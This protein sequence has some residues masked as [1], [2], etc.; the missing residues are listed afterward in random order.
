MYQQRL[1]QVLEIGQQ[2]DHDALAAGGLSSAGQELM[3]IW[4]DLDRG[5]I[6]QEEA[7]TQAD[8]AARRRAEKEGQA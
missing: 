2:A 7:F 6:H 5:A 4:D 3:H 8:H 1:D